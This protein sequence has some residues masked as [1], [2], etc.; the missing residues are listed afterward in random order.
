ML[1][2]IFGLTTSQRLHRLKLNL[3]PSWIVDELPDGVSRDGSGTRICINFMGVEG[4]SR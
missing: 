3:R 2:S 1:M 4:R